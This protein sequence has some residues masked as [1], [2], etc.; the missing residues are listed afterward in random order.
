MKK[1]EFVDLHLHSTKS[2]G[3]LTPA[4]LVEKAVGLGL[5][6][7]A[8]TDHDSIEGVKEAMVVAK[9]RIEVVPGVEISCDEPELGFM[10]V[11]VLGYFF[12]PDSKVLNDLLEKAKKERINQKKKI[13]RKLQKI[14]FKITFKEVVTLVKGEVGR[15]HIA[16]VLLKKYPKKFSSIR[17]VFLKYIH[18]SGPAYAERNHLTSVNEAIKAI[19]KS[20]G[21]AA[22]G[23]P[24]VF[25]KEDV[26]RLVDYFIKC[27]GKGIEIYYPYAKLYAHEG[28]TIRQEKETITRLK[29]MAR[30]KNLFETGGSD[31]HGGD[32]PVDINEKQ[33]SYSV[34][35]KLKNFSP[36]HFPV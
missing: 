12:D 20:G 21:I 14:G 22:L 6:A 26:P 15:P 4:E 33:V 27:G 1:K 9:G 29:K 11:H 3:K 35:L 7:I 34:F 24:A 17:D 36:A 2:D 18:N 28:F 10:D 23:H 16:Q 31:F 19:V 32:R 8:I 25:K 30:E 13:V 5:K